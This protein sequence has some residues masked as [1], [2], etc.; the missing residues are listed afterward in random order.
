MTRLI[1]V[2]LLLAAVAI[3]LKL[4]NRTNTTTRAIKVTSRVTISRGSMIAVVEIDGRRLLIGAAPNQVNLISE[5]ADVAP[6]DP[7]VPP[8]SNP[9]PRPAAAAIARLT[10]TIRPGA[11]RDSSMSR[12]DR[13][14]PTPTP[15][16]ATPVAPPARV[17]PVVPDEIESN[18]LVDRVRRMT[19]RTVEP[20]FRLPHQSGGTT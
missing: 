5:L 6:V 1:V 4:R 17:T 11:Q 16:R 2:T 8:S 3:F 14:A 13:P 7:T 10:S 12:Q 9:S 20:K 15:T 18:N 19:A